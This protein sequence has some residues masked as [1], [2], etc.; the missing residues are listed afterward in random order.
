MTRPAEQPQPQAQETG[1]RSLSM[2]NLGPM[3]IL[4]DTSVP[5]PRVP[6][7]GEYSNVGRYEPTPP[8]QDPYTYLDSQPAP[9]GVFGRLTS[10]LGDVL[11]SRPAAQTAGAMGAGAMV[12]GPVGANIDQSFSIRDIPAEVQTEG[13]NYSRKADGS[14]QQQTV[15]KQEASPSAVPSAAPSLAPSFEPGTSF[16]PGTSPDP[17]ASPIPPEE[18]PPDGQPPIA[19]IDGTGTVLETPAPNTEASPSAAPDG[20]PKPPTDLTSADSDLL[21]TDADGDG[22]ID[23]DVDGDGDVDEDDKTAVV[24]PTTALEALDLIN[25]EITVTTS[26]QL[27]AKIDALY[28]DESCAATLNTLRLPYDYADYYV[29][30]EYING[31]TKDMFGKKVGLPEKILAAEGLTALVLFLFESSDLPAALKN[32]LFDTANASSDF[33]KTKMLPYGNTAREKDLRK[34][35]QKTIDKDVIGNLDYYHYLVEQQA[36][37][38]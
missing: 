17:N 29:T 12:V 33:S 5:Y 31:Y 32:P 35:T 30:R 7:Y 23:G 14:A 24:L 18:C 28:A 4:I 10:R 38:S 26:A 20:S 13:Q 19:A 2:A 9:T 37:I 11:R 25:S 34:R 21:P 8:V 36:T 15:F 1:A 22:V 27:K 16:D 3:E 6:H